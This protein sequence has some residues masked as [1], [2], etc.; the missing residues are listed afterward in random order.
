MKIAIEATLAQ[1]HKTGTGKYVY[2]LVKTLSELDKKNEYFLLYDSK[3]WRGPQFGKN[4]QYISYNSG[5]KF[6]PVGS[7]LNSSLRK[8]NPNIMHITRILG[9]NK[10]AVCPVI[11]TVHDIF[12]IL[13]QPRQSK[14]RKLFSKQLI[15]NVTENSDYYIFNSMFTKL[16]FTVFF[17][18]PDNKSKV[19]YLGP[20]ANVIPPE[21][22]R[23]IN[24]IIICAGAIEQRRQQLFLLD[25]YKELLSK[26]EDIPPLVFIGDDRGDGEKLINTINKYNLTG[27]VKWEKDASREQIN[28]LYQNASLA[29]QPSSYEGFGIPLTEAMCCHLPLICSDISVFREVARE[30][31]IYARLR[32][33]NDWVELIL[34]FYRKRP[35]TKTR[36]A[37]KLLEERNWKICA[38]KTFECYQSLSK[39]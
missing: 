26:K 4:F 27:K 31:P 25:V 2:H 29:L 21:E 39:L 1:S 3:E 10:K 12:P 8:I 20:S 24:G 32:D 38:E 30:Y 19:I 14:I 37:D 22:K 36:L 16:E 34:K 11:T 9:V 13:E 7:R 5:N 33:K 28:K 18:I 35:K 15:N 6:F 17:N 23:S